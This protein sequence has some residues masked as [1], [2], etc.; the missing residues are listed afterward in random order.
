M[1][2]KYAC[3]QCTEDHPYRVRVFK[4]QRGRKGH[5]RR[6]GH[7]AEALDADYREVLEGV[8]RVEAEDQLKE[9]ATF[10]DW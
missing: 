2:W 1:A 10:S 8:R 7:V 3:W 6:T 4:G 9:I 5:E